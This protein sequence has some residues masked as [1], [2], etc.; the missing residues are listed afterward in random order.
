MTVTL[1]GNRAFAA[2]NLPA[3]GQRFPFVLEIKQDG[4]GGR[5]ASWSSSF[6]HPGGTAPTLSTAANATD[7]V[8][9]YAES[10]GVYLAT[11]QKGI[12]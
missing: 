6:N 9:G 10:T 8:G 4:T 1:G 7:M 3:A 5:T 11:L 12:D 2:S